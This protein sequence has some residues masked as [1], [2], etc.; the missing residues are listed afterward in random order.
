MWSRA[1][2]AL[3]SRPQLLIRHSSRRLNLS[4]QIRRTTMAT[5]AAAPAVTT[6]FDALAKK[7]KDISALGGISGLLGWDEMV[8]LPPGAGDARANQKAALA[9]VIHEKQVDPALG[10]LITRL[11]TADLSPLN[12]YQR[13]TVR[14]A[15][16]DYKKATAVTEELVRREAELESRGYATWVKARQEK[17]F[18]KFAPV[19]NEWVDARKERAALVDPNLPPYDVLADDYSAGLTA[20]RLTEIFDQVKAGLIPFLA[21][22]KARGSAPDSAWLKG[23]YDTVVQAELCQEIA[24][25]L[26]FDLEKG[27]L[28]VSVHPFTG[29]A[30]PTDVRMTTRFKKDD[31]TEGLTGAIHE[32]GH[33]LYEQ[34]RNLE[35]D[36]LPV[37]SAAGMA[38]H[39]SQSLL[40]ERM[41]ALS[42]PFAEYLLPK[43]RAAFPQFPADRSAKDLYEAINVIRDP[44]FIRVEADEVTYPLH[45]ILRFEVEKGLIEGTVSVEEIPALWNA[46]MKEY[47]G[48][49]PDDDA[50]G[51]L[52]DVHWSAGLFG[53]FPT[54]TLGAMSA[55]QIFDAAK[56]ELPTL[57][58]DLAAGNFAPLR[59]WLNEK[60]HSVGSLHPTADDL[61]EAVTG[62]PLDPQIF[63]NYL[64]AKYTTLYKL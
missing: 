3:P 17:D 42:L 50:Q 36:G 49:E 44:S 1:A 33:A 60:V 11:K 20:A 5:A 41:V 23:E 61:L 4:S 9:G 29:G 25:A 16:R 27:R 24:V 53:Y 38:I 59:K 14:E 40:W 37:N 58:A 12:E 32:T 22:V 31:V 21:D 57:D 51:C 52:Q 39:E 46:K 55:V 54:Y 8:Q 30:H 10:D 18:S 15:A 56:K 34:G 26:G 2:C 47:L 35:Y 64:K 13:A 6:D 43:L 62:K 19:L 63:L 45:I 28:D 48:V 7:L